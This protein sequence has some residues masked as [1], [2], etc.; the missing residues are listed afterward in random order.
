[1]KE[2]EI[3]NNELEQLFETIIEQAPLI[4]E[5]QVNT[6]LIGLSTA[7]HGNAFKHFF[8]NRLNTI[9]FSVSLIVITILVALMLLN[10]ADTTET[11]VGENSP[12]STI[13]LPACE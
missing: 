13:I 6:I 5:D 10:K 8:Q 3:T 1:M 2:R 9:L 11:S 7:T 12:Q 4:A